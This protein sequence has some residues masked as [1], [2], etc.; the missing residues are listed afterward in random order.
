MCVRGDKESKLHRTTP[1]QLEG[2]LEQT[3]TNW[4]GHRVV[5]GQNF[6]AKERLILLKAIYVTP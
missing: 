6:F 2:K 4:V 1:L 3:Y 5:V